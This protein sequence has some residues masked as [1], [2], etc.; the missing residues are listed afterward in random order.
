MSNAKQ[1]EHSLSADVHFRAPT[2]FLDRVHKV[3]RING[4]TASN[5]MRFAIMQTMDRMER[6]VSE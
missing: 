5:F 1:P 2:D 6:Q 3:A 4:M